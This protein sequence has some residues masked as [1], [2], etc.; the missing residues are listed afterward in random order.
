MQYKRSVEDFPRECV[1]VS[2]TM[3]RK[4][5]RDKTGNRRFWPVKVGSID[6]DKLRADVDQLWAEAAH[7]QAAGESCRMR[8]EIY[9]LARAEQANRTEG[10]PIHEKL[11]ERLGQFEDATISGS[12]IRKLLGI[13]D[14]KATDNQYKRIGRA[15]KALGWTRKRV[16]LGAEMKVGYAYTIGDESNLLE[17]NAPSAGSDPSVYVAAPEV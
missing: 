6:L 17:V 15:M 5:L 14:S 7:R 13:E 10:D 16:R 12:N 1:M 3:N 9:A 2:C 4:Y 11:E 8:P